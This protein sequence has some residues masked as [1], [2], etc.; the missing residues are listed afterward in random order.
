LTILPRYEADKLFQSE[1]VT[2]NLSTKLQAQ[3]K[4]EKALK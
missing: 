3:R 1:K 2:T 4:E